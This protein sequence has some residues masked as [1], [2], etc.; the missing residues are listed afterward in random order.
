M[1]ERDFFEYACAGGFCIRDKRRSD[2]RSSQRDAID[3]RLGSSG[4]CKIDL[5]C[6]S[7]GQVCISKEQL[8]THRNILNVFNL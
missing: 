3:A 2:P 7:D 8:S 5:D 4:T 1:N 6:V